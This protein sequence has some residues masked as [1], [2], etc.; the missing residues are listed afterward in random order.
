VIDPDDC[1]ALAR[2]LASTNPRKGGWEHFNR[3]LQAQA[4]S[5][6]AAIGADA[7]SA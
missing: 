4:R 1:K 6:L 7:D 5:T 3:A 2:R